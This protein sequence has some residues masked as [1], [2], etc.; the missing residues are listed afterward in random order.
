[1]VRMGSGPF[2]KQGD[3]ATKDLVEQEAPLGL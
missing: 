1:M 2:Q 3:S